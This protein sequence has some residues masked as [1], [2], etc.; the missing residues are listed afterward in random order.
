[1]VA[2]PKIKPI[3][4]FS[5]PPLRV[6]YDIVQFRIRNENIL[7]HLEAQGY[8]PWVRHPR[9]FESNSTSRGSGGRVASRLVGRAP[10]FQ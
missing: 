9:W 8:N 2:S 1:M 7:A 10:G 5:Q 6:L 3:I 4:P